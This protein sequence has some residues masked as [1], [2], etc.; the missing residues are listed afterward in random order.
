[1]F[2]RTL[3][4]TAYDNPAVTDARNTANEA[5]NEALRV[6]TELELLRTD[7]ER[8]LMISEALWV[9]LK[10]EHG[11]SDEKLRDVVTQ[12]DRK[13]SRECPG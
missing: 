4:D 10:Q 6:R 12:I 8:L 11:Y 9:L 7:V 5:K 3:F 2:Y 13:R 1:M